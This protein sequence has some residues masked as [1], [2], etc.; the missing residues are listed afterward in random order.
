VFGFRFGSVQ[1]GIILMK[2]LLLAGVAALSVLASAAQTFA[3]KAKLPDE[4]LG[5]WCGQWGY[6]FPNDDAE[7]WWRAEDVEECGNRGGVHVR[8]DG[9]DYNRFGPQGSC[10]FTAIEFSRHGEPTDHVRPAGPNGEIEAEAK[11]EAPPS[12]VYL[13]RA[14]CKDDA[15]SWNE[16]YDIQTSDAWLIRWPLAEG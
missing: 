16:T 9:Y 6:Q 8:K 13:V 14:T 7:H 2:K 3:T 11:A 10:E 4:M 1:F 15:Q 5:A 12:D